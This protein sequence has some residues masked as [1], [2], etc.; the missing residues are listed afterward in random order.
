MKNLKIKITVQETV[1]KEI[2]KEITLPYYSKGEVYVYKV[3][4]DGDY[5]TLRIRATE[6]G[7]YQID[8]YDNF[9]RAIQCD[10]CTE[11]EFNNAL[12]KAKSIL[13]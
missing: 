8:N 13:L 10:P 9:Q 4:G 7:W 3:L 12:E 2:E 1:Q 5:E 6:L 11:Q